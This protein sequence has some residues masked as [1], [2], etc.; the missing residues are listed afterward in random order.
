VCAVSW[1]GYACP[2]SHRQCQQTATWVIEKAIA[3]KNKLGCQAHRPKQNK[4]KRSFLL[5]HECYS[6]IGQ[7]EMNKEG[8]TTSRARCD[9]GLGGHGN[10][11]SM[12]Q[13][14]HSIAMIRVEG[15]R[16]GVTCGSPRLHALSFFPSLSFSTATGRNGLLMFLFS[17]G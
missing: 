15:T 4:I 9:N 7:R 6:A 11:S 3:Q 10:R 5:A 8:Q 16:V 1:L 13:G 17:H 2:L 12:A 14:P